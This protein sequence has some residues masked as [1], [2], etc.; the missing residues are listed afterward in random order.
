MYKALTVAGS[1]SGGGAGIQTDLKTFAALGVYGASVIT[2]LTAQNTRGVHGIHHVPAAFIVSQLEAVLSDIPVTAVKTG[3]LGEAEAIAE[4]ARVLAK[5]R[6]N[7]LVVDPVMVAQSGDTLLAPEA[8]TIM[9]DRLLPMALLVTPNLPEAG[10][11]LGR[12]ISGT[13]EMAAAARD[14]RLLG[15]RHVLIKGGHLPGDEMVD[16]FYDGNAVHYLSAPKIHTVHTHGT[17]CTYAAAITAFL[18]RGCTPLEAVR[19]GKQFIS[20]AIRYGLSIG[21]GYGP[22]NPMGS[23]LRGL[24]EAKVLESVC[25]A[26]MLLQRIPGAEKLLAPG[27]SNLYYCLEHA[28]SADDIASFPAPFVLRCRQII[29]ADGPRFGLQSFGTEQL[30]SAQQQDESVRS[31]LLL[32]FTEEMLDAAEALA[33]PPGHADNPGVPDFPRVVFSRG[34]QNTPA[35]LGLLGSDPFA[36]SRAVERLANCFRFC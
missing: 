5:Y 7:L 30:L 22:T 14:I 32:R 11:L 13:E 25:R 34:E 8:V 1:D 15:P 18:A 3:M 17:G 21:A 26:F 4:I 23:L 28:T 20:A 12:D 19:Q 29:A 27:L 31:L 2:A 9:R 16:V 24:A 35:F 10:V 6:R 36:L 33:L